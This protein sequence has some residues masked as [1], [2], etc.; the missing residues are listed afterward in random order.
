MLFSVNE[1]LCYYN[2][3]VPTKTILTVE[4]LNIKVFNGVR[5][6]V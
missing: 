3:E 2:N 4:E 5:N 6:E 1:Y